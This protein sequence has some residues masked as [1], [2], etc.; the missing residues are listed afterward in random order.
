MSSIRVVL[1]VTTASPELY[2]GLKEVPARLRAE[3]VRMLATLGIMAV[4]GG[5]AT[6]TTSGI[7]STEPI[8]DRDLGV[9]HRAFA[10]AKSLGDGI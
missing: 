10:L 1:T 4:A 6:S 3:R 9:S 8:K 2:A 5:G 7:G